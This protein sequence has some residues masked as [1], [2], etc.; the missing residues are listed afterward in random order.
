LAY[1]SNLSAPG[2]T[3]CGRT[4]RRGLSRC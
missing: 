2:L 4:A 3:T 1:I